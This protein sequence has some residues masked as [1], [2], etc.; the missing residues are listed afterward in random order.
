MKLMS[1]DDSESVIK[2]QILTWLTYQKILC[3]NQESVGVYDVKRQAFRKKNSRFQKRGVADI[4]GVYN[5]R[6]LA[7]E[8][9]SKKGVLSGYQKEFLQEFS[10]AGGIALMVRS[11]DEVI[12]FFKMYSTIE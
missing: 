10:D 5:G 1:G 8:V 11:L 2:N 4:L 9:K 7:I 6:A 12:R 3:W